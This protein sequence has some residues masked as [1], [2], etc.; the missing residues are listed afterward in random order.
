MRFSA[1][2]PRDVRLT[3]S[4]YDQGP[5]DKKDRRYDTIAG[6]YYLRRAKII[7]LAFLPTK[8]SFI[9]NPSCYFRIVDILGS[10]K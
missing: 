6:S 1:L 7:V 3:S 5:G 2:D 10:A 4:R 9:R 8:T